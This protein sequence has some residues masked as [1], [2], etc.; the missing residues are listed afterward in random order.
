M[1]LVDLLNQKFELF[2]KTKVQNFAKQKSETLGR[3]KFG[4]QMVDVA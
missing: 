4:I 2:A 3:R 1:F